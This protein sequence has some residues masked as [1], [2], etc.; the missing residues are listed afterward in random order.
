MKRL[1]E[2][3][4]PAPS[5]MSPE[6]FLERLRSERKRVSEVLQQ[7]RRQPQKKKKKSQGARAKK[8]K[9]PSLQESFLTKLKEKGLTLEE[10]EQKLLAKAKG[11]ED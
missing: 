10:F 9:G 4:G 6:K 8:V 7:F 3:I 11:E 2:I 5:E 1:R